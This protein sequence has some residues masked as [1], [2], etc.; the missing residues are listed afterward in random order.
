MSSDSYEYVELTRDG[1]KTVIRLDDPKRRN[2]LSQGMIDDLSDTLEEAERDD[3]AAVVLTGSDGTF[4]AGG[5]IKSFTRE[6]HEAISGHLFGDSDFRRPFDLIEGLETPVIAAVNGVAFGGGFELA[7]VSDMVIVGEDVELGTPETTIGIA[8]GVAFVRLSGQI[9]HH[10]AM[11][12]MLTG[13]RI[14][15]SEAIEMGLFNEAVPVE[16]VDDVVDDYVD[17]L[18]RAAPLGIAVTK[19]VANRHRG[20][21]DRAI[22]DLA[23]ATLL[24]SEDADE[25]LS[26]FAEK[27]EPEFQGK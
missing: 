22:A 12:L 11:E 26:A 21:E 13:T 1:P 25:G 24:E 7:L 27:R 4:C 17:R 3:S 9:G 23:M 19:K 18:D 6:G 5:D 10:Q 2:S 20:G 14:T 8:P 15:G 16:D